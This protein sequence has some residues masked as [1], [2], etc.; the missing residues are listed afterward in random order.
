M[1]TY[2][3][4]VWARTA[5]AMPPEGIVV[6]TISP[7]GLQQPLKLVG[8]LWYIPDGTTYVYYDPIMWSWRVGDD[9]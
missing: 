1:K 6:D 4:T 5:E 3:N 8:R 2:G 7:G 9:D